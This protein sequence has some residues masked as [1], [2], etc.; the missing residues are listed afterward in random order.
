[1]SNFREMAEISAIFGCQK[2]IQNLR[3]WT[4]YIILK[5]VIWWFQTYYLFREIFRFCDFAENTI[6]PPPSYILQKCVI[7]NHIVP[8]CT[9]EGK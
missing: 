7:P 8:S 3:V 2:K 4:L 6:V 1:M 9:T 5:Y